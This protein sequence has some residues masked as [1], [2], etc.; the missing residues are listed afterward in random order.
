MRP[1]AFRSCCILSVLL[2]A[3]LLHDCRGDRSDT[4]RVRI[5]IHQSDEAIRQELLG[6]TPLGSDAAAVLEFVYLHLSVEGRGSGVGLMARPTI[7]AILGHSPRYVFMS[8][9]VEAIWRFDERRKLRSLEIQRYGTKGSPSSRNDFLS[10]VQIDLQQSNEEIRRILLGYTPLGS[11]LASIVRFI[12]LRLYAQSSEASGVAL[13]GKPG[14]AV[15]LGEY[16]DPKSGSPRRVLVNWTRD[17]NQRLKDIEVSR[18]SSLDV[19][20]KN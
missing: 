5:D 14:L 8:N 19:L 7:T 17:S 9:N 11:D 13:T 12:M 20:F 10:P 15:I 6:Y 1:L 18:V 16:I 2:M 3:P 4:A